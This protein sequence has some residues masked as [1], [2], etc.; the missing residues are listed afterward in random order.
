MYKFIRGGIKLFALSVCFVVPAIAEEVSIDKS[1]EALE[2]PSS[3]LDSYRLF[4]SVQERKTELSAATESKSHVAVQQNAVSS[5]K[6]SKKAPVSVRSESTPVVD[7]KTVVHFQALLESE[8]T[9][10]LIINGIPCEVG[11]VLPTQNVDVPMAVDC[12]SA[13]LPGINLT[14]ILASRMLAV[15]NPKGVVRLLSLGGSL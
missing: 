11:T 10:R 1:M 2:L 15:E 9:F 7:I 4:F 8:S 12:H 5:E 13:A 6:T 3:S 14:L